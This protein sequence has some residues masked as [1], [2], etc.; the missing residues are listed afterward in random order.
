MQAA[1]LVHRMASGTHKRWEQPTLSVGADGRSVTR[2]VELHVYPRSRGRIL[3]HIGE[4][5]E[6]AVELLVA[7]RLGSMTVALRH[8]GS[9]NGG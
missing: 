9:S 2:N 1:K 6:E 8:A 7:H 5:L 4:D 3:R